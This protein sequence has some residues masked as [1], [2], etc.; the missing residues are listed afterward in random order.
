MLFGCLNGNT[1]KSHFYSQVS[2][3]HTH[4]LSRSQAPRIHCLYVVA[5]LSLD[6]IADDICMCLVMHMQLVEVAE[7]HTHVEP[8][9][10]EYKI[11]LVS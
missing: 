5:A 8:Q 10:T 4:K 9:N 11:S 6:D 1:S 7:E 2:Y 3:P